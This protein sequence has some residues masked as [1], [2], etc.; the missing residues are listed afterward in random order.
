MTE[1]SL[2]YESLSDGPFEVSDELPSRIDELELWNVNIDK[3]SE[4]AK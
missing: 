1:E 2:H 3:L 4:T